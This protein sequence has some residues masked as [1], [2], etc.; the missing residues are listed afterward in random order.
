MDPAHQAPTARGNSSLDHDAPPSQTWAAVGGEAAESVGPSNT[1]HV[2]LF[3]SGVPAT[4][5]S[6]ATDFAGGETRAHAGPLHALSASRSMPSLANLSSMPKRIARPH[7]RQP[8]VQ[9]QTQIEQAQKSADDP[10]T[11]LE[12]ENGRRTT[13]DLMRSEHSVRSDI[14]RLFSESANMTGSRAPSYA[15]ATGPL[16]LRGTCIR[17][18]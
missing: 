6:A 12:N 3:S 1:P 18:Y 8:I 4:R 15:N 7:D 14:S 10:T 13:M 9:L 16:Y 2:S 5:P 11:P 17:V